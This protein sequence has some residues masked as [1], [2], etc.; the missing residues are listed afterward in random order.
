[1]KC[2]HTVTR[3]NSTSVFVEGWQPSTRRIRSLDM[4]ICYSNK[5]ASDS[6]ADLASVNVGIVPLIL[7][8]LKASLETVDRKRLMRC[9]F[10][11][12]R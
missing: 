6:S 5:A 3:S 1:M 9:L 4:S 10:S 8:S 7:L 12:M 2:S 11:A